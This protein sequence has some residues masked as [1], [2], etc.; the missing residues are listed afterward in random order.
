MPNW[1]RRYR[2]A[3]DALAAEDYDALR[4]TAH[5]L[6][7]SS[8]SSGATGVSERLEA[9]ETWCRTTAPN[10]PETAHTLVRAVSE[11]AAAA[12]AEMEAYLEALPEDDA[13]GAP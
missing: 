12:Q 1:R 13:V 2:V 4:D 10:A 6:K 8:Y 5:A 11:A 7:S 9:L 3:A